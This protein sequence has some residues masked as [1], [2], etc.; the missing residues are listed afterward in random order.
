M[1]LDLKNTVSGNA[2]TGPALKAVPAP[3][4]ETVQHKAAFSVES[5][6]FVAFLLDIAAIIGSFMAMSSWSGAWTAAQDPFYVLFAITLAVWCGV[7]LT[8]AG[9][10]RFN[11]LRSPLR[12]LR[13]ILMPL[14]GAY[15]AALYFTQ[16]VIDPIL[17]AGT[18][19]VSALGLCIVSVTIVRILGV[20]LLLFA[21]QRSLVA[22]RI[23]ILGG[24]AQGERL[25]NHLKQDGLNVNRVLG[26]FDDRQVAES[27]VSE[28][29]TLLGTSSDLVD[30]VKRREIDDI[31]VALP[32]TA[33]HRLRELIAEL[34]IYPV[35]IRLGA[36]LAAF[37]FPGKMNTDVLTGLPMI[38]ISNNPLAGWRRLAKAIEDKLLGGLLFLLFSPIMAAV[39]IAIKLDTPGPVFFKQ[40]R[41]GFN[42][43]VFYVYKFRS[44]IHGHKKP[45]EKTVQASR[46]DPRITRVGK[47]IRRTSLDELPQLINVLNGS[48]SLVGPRPHALDHNE[49]YGRVIDNYF[50]RHRVKPGIT[51]LAQVNGLRGETDTLDKMEYRVRYDLHYVENWSILVDLEI[52]A[53]TGFIGFFGRNAY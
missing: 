40:K 34:S 47:F 31:I 45:K 52:L 3:P 48:M 4:R 30:A 15:C 26:V 27:R 19:T 5:T 10:Y 14:A 12:H 53:L 20:Y 23:A 13:R 21:T 11:I 46:D 8:A 17:L 41:L 6:G 28:S 36:D 33:E 44:M 18:W 37:Q 16:F 49:E 32:W 38:T 39:A 22:R 51:G 43:Q 42:N 9:S 24:G 1:G 50:A 25:I 2:N 35:N 29:V 7:I